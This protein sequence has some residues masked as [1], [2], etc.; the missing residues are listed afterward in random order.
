MFEKVYANYGEK[1]QICPKSD[2]NIV[3][4]FSLLMR[5]FEWCHEDANDDIDM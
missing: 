1:S 3:V 2:K 4:S 5:L